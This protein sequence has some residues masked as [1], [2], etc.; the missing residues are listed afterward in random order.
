M[1]EI[2]FISRVLDKSAAQ[3]KHISYKQPKPIRTGISTDFDDYFSVFFFVIL[4]CLS[5]AG[6]R[7]EDHKNVSY[8]SRCHF[9]VNL[10]SSEHCIAQAIRS[11]EQIRP[12]IMTFC[13]RLSQT[14]K[15]NNN[16]TT[17]D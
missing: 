10:Q 15:K 4:V 2:F 7:E 11:V 3:N 13:K 17:M 6:K 12:W 8:Q 9:H 16:S 1:P 5:T 14:K